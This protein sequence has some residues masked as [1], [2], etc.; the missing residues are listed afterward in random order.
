[1]WW[2][3]PKISWG[4]SKQNRDLCP[5]E[6]REERAL[7]GASYHTGSFRRR[8][9]KRCVFWSSEGLTKLHS[10]W[11][12]AEGSFVLLAGLGRGVGCGVEREQVWGPGQWDIIRHGLI[13]DQER[14]WSSSEVTNADT[15]RGW[16]V[17]AMSQLACP[18]FLLLQPWVHSGKEDGWASWRVRQR[19]EQRQPPAEALRPNCLSTQGVRV[20][21]SWTIQPQQSHQLTTEVSPAGP[22]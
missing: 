11:G 22:D 9:K 7:P 18:V 15:N 16:C 20:R 17:A 4:P 14:T 5:H 6:S 13:R 2:S 19:M 8:R 21:P 10:S 3:K 1:M 12:G